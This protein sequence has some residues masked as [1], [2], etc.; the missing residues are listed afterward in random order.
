[1]PS[2]RILFATTDY[3]Y[4]TLPIT[5]PLRQLG[6]TVKIFDYYRPNLLVRS[7]GWLSNRHVLP[8]TW[9]NRLINQALLSQIATFR[10]HYLLVIKGDTL[11]SH[12]INQINQEGIITIN[13]FPDWLVSWR[14]VKA[15]APSYTMFIN[16]CYDTF[17]KLDQLGIKNY[18]LPYAAPVPTRKR[19]LT[20]KYAITFIGQHSPRRERYFRAIADLDLHI[21]GYD[22][23]RTSSLSHLFH[24]QTSQAQTQAIIARSRIVVNILTG[25]DSFQPTAVNI[26]TFEALSAGT[27]LLAKDHPILHRHFKVGKELITFTSPQDLRRKVKYYLSHDQEREKIAQTGYNR[28]LKSHTFNHR[29]KELFRIVNHHVKRN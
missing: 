10:P 29:L 18:Y 6:F 5:K 21:W 12:T 16:S 17:E 27:F 7:V 3:S 13:W 26:R 22:R 2:K 15:H 24:N 19:P 11:T 1:M 28:I 4:F 20:E 25:T 14:W 23:W 8:K 9:P